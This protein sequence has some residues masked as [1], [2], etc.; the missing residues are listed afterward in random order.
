M[1]SSNLHDLL[2]SGQA[3]LLL[4]PPTHGTNN[5]RINAFG[6]I[7]NENSVGNETKSSSVSTFQSLIKKWEEQKNNSNYDPTDCL[8]EMADILEKVRH[9]FGKVK[10]LFGNFKD[11][12]LELL[13]Q[14][15]S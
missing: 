8:N 1:S 6:D 13:Y 15:I 2:A 10:R 9:G 14:L 11:L 3:P 5:V 4:R 12:L 7:N